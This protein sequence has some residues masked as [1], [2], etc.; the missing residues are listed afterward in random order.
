MSS[1]RN[2]GVLSLFGYTIAAAD[3]APKTSLGDGGAKG[4]RPA[5]GSAG[6]RVGKLDLHFYPE[7]FYFAALRFEGERF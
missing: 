4:A 1:F 2:L 3:L 6:L 7:H 5:T